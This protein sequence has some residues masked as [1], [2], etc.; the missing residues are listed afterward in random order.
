[1]DERQVSGLGALAA[2]ADADDGNNSD[3]ASDAISPRAVL[4]VIYLPYT[5]C[6]S[7]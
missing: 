7:C 1:M 3:S 4:P 2:A 5:G 6:T